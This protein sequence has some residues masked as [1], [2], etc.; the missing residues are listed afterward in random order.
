MRRL[1]ICYGLKQPPL[2]NGAAASSTPTPIG[3]QQ[4]GIPQVA[5]INEMIRQGWTDHSLS[6]SPPASDI[7]WCRRVYLDVLGRIPSAAELDRFSSRPNW[8]KRKLNLVNRL[9][10]EGPVEERRRSAGSTK[11]Y[12]EEYARNWTTIWTNIL[13]GRNG[14]NE[15]RTL[16]SRE[17]MQQYLRAS[18]LRNK[19]YD[20]MVYELVTA[21]GVNKPR[22]EGLQRRRR[23][24]LIGK[25]DENGVQATAKTA[26]IFLGLQVQ[27]TQCHNH[28]FNEWKQKKFWELN[29]FFR[30]TRARRV[31]RRPRRQ[32]AG[33]IVQRRFRRREP[34]ADAGRS[35][36]SSTSCAT[37]LSAAAFPVFVDRHR[38][39][40]AAACLSKVESPHRAG[41]AD[42]RTRD[43]M[44]TV[45]VNRMWAHFLGYGFTK[46]ID[47]MGPHNPPT[48]PELLEYAGRG[49]PQEQ[50]QHQG[51]DPLD[52]A[53]RSRI[54]FPAASHKPNKRDD[55]SLGE[56]PQFST[57]TC[58]RCRP[59]SCT[60]RCSWPPRPR[61][62]NGSY[63]EQERIEGRVAA[64]VHDRLRHRR[65][66]RGHDLQR[67]DPA[68]AD[69][70]QR[71][72]GAQGDRRR[73]GSFLRPG[74][75]ES[76]PELRGAR[77][78]YLFIRR[79]GRKANNGEMQFCEARC[80]SAHK[81]DQLKALQD[82]FWVV[83][84]SN[85]FILNH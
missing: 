45:M 71:R 70:V 15:Q 51:A 47:D 27:C 21:T 50:L 53:E 78:T 74:R 28:P 61:R 79:L 52:H 75:R 81:G 2:R 36:R 63:E 3:R 76:E 48:H 49:L 68:G 17:G 62:R 10:G 4:Y 67:H 69:D 39:Q 85:E 54:R 44:P 14:G 35:A 57:S 23:T 9:L 11:H 32:V 13:I 19:P 55:P 66:G 16:I 30:Q 43:Y 12:T 83:L 82:V 46:P 65:R 59:S 22:R 29:A 25:L 38:D 80:W 20:T 41:Q 7:E 34:I 84:N 64:A 18:F 58:G 33:A 72:P 60:N 77:S 8:S 37:A 24:S 31:G 5:Y 26:Q 40:S 56:K 1:P 6:P 42:R 73:A